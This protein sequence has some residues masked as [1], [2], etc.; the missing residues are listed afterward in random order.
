MGVITAEEKLEIKIKTHRQL[1]WIGVFSIVMMFAGLSSGYIVGKGDKTWVK[2]FVPDAF[3]VSTVILLFSSVTYFFAVRSIKDGK[4]KI[5]LLMVGLTLILGVTFTAYQVKGWSYLTERNC[6]FGGGTSIR[7]V[8]END[9]AVY[10]KDYIVVQKGK[11]LDYFEGKFYD[12][13]DVNHSAPN[14]KVALDASNNSSSFFFLM[15]GLHVFHL[16]FGLISLVL[17][18]VKTIRKKYSIEDHIGIKVSAIYWHF[19]DFLWLYLL[20]LLYF[21]G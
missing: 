21:V 20:G 14:T 4:Q 11:E 7:M 10:G 12:P 15:T 3:F 6:N 5:A 16:L 17:V 9:V 2:I 18:F 13:R 1:M 19:L 8:V